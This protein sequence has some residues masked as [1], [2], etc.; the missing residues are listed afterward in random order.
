MTM[1]LPPFGAG[2]SP[3]V[4]ATLLTRSDFAQ[5]VHGTG[6]LVDYHPQSKAPAVLD[7]LPA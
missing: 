7:G 5:V 1:T 4:G 3:Y 6:S 2:N